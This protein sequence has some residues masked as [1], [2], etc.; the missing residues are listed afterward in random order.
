MTQ[1]GSP[2]AT[3]MKLFQLAARYVQGGVKQVGICQ[4][5]ER[6]KWRNISMEYG[7]KAVSDIFFFPESRMY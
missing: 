2:Q 5:V 3:G 4:V 7:A 1:T 6:L